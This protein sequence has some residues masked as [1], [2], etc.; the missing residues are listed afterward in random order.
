VSTVKRKNQ[1][2]LPR[3]AAPRGAPSRQIEE[4][5]AP[6]F[7]AP[8]RNHCVCSTHING[9]NTLLFIWARFRKGAGMPS[10]NLKASPEG[11]S[12]HASAAQGPTLVADT[13]CDRR[14]TLE[15]G[16]TVFPSRSAGFL[17]AGSRRRPGAQ[18][19]ERAAG[20]PCIFPLH[21][22]SA[23]RTCSRGR[24]RIARLPET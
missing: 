24:D 1:N 21:A 8:G 7:R 6:I 2:T 10:A 17:H 4:A 16:R 18:P 9:W 12:G 19:P 15:A 3:H 20:S 22:G 23:S 11:R 14:V 13:P 5:Q